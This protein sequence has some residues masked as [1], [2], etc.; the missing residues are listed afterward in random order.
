MVTA[1]CNRRLE[2]PRDS[3][4]VSLQ[5]PRSCLCG[6]VNRCPHLKALEPGPTFLMDTY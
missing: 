4:G 5:V 6:N 1:T 2:T 3:R